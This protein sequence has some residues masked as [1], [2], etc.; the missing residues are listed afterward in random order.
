MPMAAVSLDTRADVP[1]TRAS[2]ALVLLVRVSHL[3]AGVAGCGRRYAR[4]LKLA[5]LN[6]TVL[7][8]GRMDAFA[9]G[10]EC[11]YYCFPG[12]P[13]HWTEML[14]RMLE[15]QVYGVDGLGSAY[16]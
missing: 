16:L 15:Q 11:A 14:L 5:T 1:N 3:I 13:H 12:V 6:I 7:S 10:S 8:D 2:H 4:R 9:P